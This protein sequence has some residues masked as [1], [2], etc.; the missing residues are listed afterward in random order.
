M[1]QDLSQIA[2]ELRKETC[3]RRVLDEVE[4]Q[5]TQK[6]SAPNRLRLALS[7]A[8]AGVILAGCLSVWLWQRNKNIPSQ[9][10]NPD[11]VQVANQ[12]EYALALVGSELLDAG[13]HSEKIIS[14]RAVPPLRNSIEIAKNKIINP[15]EL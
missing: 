7:Y 12:A 6:Q 11:R 5:I 13:A 14:D 3:P 9:I 15:M 2:S 10:A 4:R 8:I 1:Q